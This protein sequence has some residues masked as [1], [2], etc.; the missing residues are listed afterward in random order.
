MQYIGIRC[1]LGAV[2][3]ELHELS[4]DL[5][6]YAARLVR[7]VRRLSESPGAAIRI[8]SLLDEF[9]P[10]SVSELARLDRS[11]QPTMSGAVTSL[12]ERDWVAKTPDPDDARA[13]V[14]TMTAAGAAA[15]ADVRRVNAD[16]VAARVTAH[17]DHDLEDLRTAVAVLR[18][19]LSA[20][21][22]GTP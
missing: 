22:E 20:T 11:S 1:S 10:L 21:S 18:D 19:L 8:V 14:V 16:A 6:V 17:P 15:L 9:G 2:D 12:V 7:A 3:G 13:S 4:G 5:V